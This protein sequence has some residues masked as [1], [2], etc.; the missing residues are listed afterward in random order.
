MPA[1]LTCQHQRPNRSHLSTEL[2]KQRV[3]SKT[4]QQNGSDQETDGLGSP[5]RAQSTL[6]LDALRAD[7]ETPG[8]L[9]SAVRAAERQ[10]PV[11]HLSRW[12]ATAL[13]FSGVRPIAGGL[14]W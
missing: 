8:N 9:E 1:H 5:R 7:L 13:N 10:V 12:A 6:I 11:R 2:G 4:G 14:T 3:D